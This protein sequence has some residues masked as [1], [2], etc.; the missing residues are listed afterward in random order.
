[1][2]GGA[3]ASSRS[4]VVSIVIPVYNGSN[5]LRE[6]VD[7][8]L[9]QTYGRTEVIVVDDGSDDGGRTDAIIRSYGDRVRRFRKPNGGVSTALNHGLREMTGE[10]FAWL[11]HDDRFAADRIEQD[12]IAAAERPEA[13]VL[14]CPIKVIDGAGNVIREPVYPVDRV[15]NPRDALRLGGVDMCAMT[16][17]R[18]CFARVGPFNEANRTTQDVEMT[19]RLSAAFPFLLS[20]RAVTFKRVHPA[21][22]TETE[23]GQVRRDIRL[24]MD[25]VHDHLSVRGFFPGLADGGT[26]PADAWIW[27]GD[28]YRSYGAHTYADEAFRNALAVP[29]AGWARALQVRARRLNSPLL[30]RLLR[31]A[32]RLARLAG[33]RA[34]AI[35]V[36][37]PAPPPPSVS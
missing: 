22:G 36:S 9:Q 26:G 18:S 33:G 17:H 25:V 24:L 13:R 6:A 11:S 21:R 29:D 31:V 27:M 10:W 15:T 14:F 16:I 5:Y 32:Q 28:L 19:L 1:M 8:A 4:P 7:S 37:D 35:D 12:M 23:A 30:D 20:P 3:R 2:T 34:S